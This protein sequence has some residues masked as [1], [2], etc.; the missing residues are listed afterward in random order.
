MDERNADRELTP[1]APISGPQLR[2][3]RA[4]LKWSVGEL[5]A[6]CGIS[7]SAIARGEQVNGTLTMQVR[8]VAAIRIV[9][10]QHGIEFLGLDGVRLLRWSS[11]SP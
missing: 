3:A 4:L 6:R 11:K 8:N 5:S 7:R 1:K 2:A 10:E 9:F